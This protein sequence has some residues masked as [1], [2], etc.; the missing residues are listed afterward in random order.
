MKL[1]NLVL[2]TS[3]NNEDNYSSKVGAEIEEYKHIHITDRRRSATLPAH[4]RFTWV[5]ATD[6]PYNSANP[7][8]WGFK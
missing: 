6:E 5:L 2:L 7:A 1:D 3:H 4:S 8:K